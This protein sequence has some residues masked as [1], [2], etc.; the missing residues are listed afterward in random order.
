MVEH[1]GEVRPTAGI[2]ELIDDDE[3]IRGVVQ[4]L[5]YEVRPDEAG[6]AGD[7]QRLCRQ[8][9]SSA[10]ATIVWRVGWGG[11]AAR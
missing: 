11:C 4:R 7:E 6:S 1:P 2:G 9:L 3:T 8:G 10:S 5:P